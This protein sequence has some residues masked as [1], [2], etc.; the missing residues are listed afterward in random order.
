MASEARLEALFQAELI[1]DLEEMFP[2]ILILKNDEQYLQGIPDL[3]LLYGNM[4]A[5]LEVKA[6]ANA[7]ER[8][9]QE[10]YVT[11]ADNMSFAAF[12]YPENKETV[13]NDLQLAFSPRRSTR[14]SQ[15]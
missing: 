4:W 6:S 11:L 5:M 15:R 3:T 7:R 9:N 8:P 1:Q 2:G 13:L 12:I 14:A 10:Y